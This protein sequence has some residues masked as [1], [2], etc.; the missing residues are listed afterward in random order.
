[1]P[2]RGHTALPLIQAEMHLKLS[3]EFTVLPKQAPGSFVYCFPDTYPLGGC[4]TALKKSHAL[5]AC[6]GN[7]H[8]FRVCG[9]IKGQN[10]RHVCVCTHMLLNTRTHACVQNIHPSVSNVSL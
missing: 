5:E 4:Y 6:A 1:M 2:S 9:G 8:T 7:V 10:R 3:K